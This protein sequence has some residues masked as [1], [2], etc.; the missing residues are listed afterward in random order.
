M[1]HQ[2]QKKSLSVRFPS[3]TWRF[4]EQQCKT[5]YSTFHCHCDFLAWALKFLLIS[6]NQ[7]M[8]REDKHFFWQHKNFFFQCFI[9]VIEKC[10]STQY[11]SRI[12]HKNAGHKMLHYP[13]YLP[14]FCTK[15][16]PS[17][18]LRTCTNNPNKH[19]AAILHMSI[20]S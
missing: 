11:L 3:R 10:I 4:H 2:S 17:R 12:I 19:L 13:H 14:W 16:S 5:Q 6:R 7:K 1:A 8:G 9:I 20:C 15:W 18:K